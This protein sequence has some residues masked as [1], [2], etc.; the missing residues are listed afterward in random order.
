MPVLAPKD[1]RPK[2]ILSKDEVYRKYSKGYKKKRKKSNRHKGLLLLLLL[3]LLA[4]CIFIYEVNNDF[5]L[6]KRLFNYLWDNRYFFI[7]Y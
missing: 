4:I 2:V 7:N 6:T 3:I 5:I 1:D